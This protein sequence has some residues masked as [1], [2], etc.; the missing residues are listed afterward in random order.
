M[1]KVDLEILIP[2][3]E[4]EKGFCGGEI[5]RGKLNVLSHQGVQC[6]EITLSMG[7]ESFGSGN[8][9]K[10]PR[11]KTQTLYAG[12]LTA[13]EQKTF[14]FEFEAPRYGPFEYEGKHLSIFYF[15]TARANIPM[16]IDPVRKLQIPIHPS[17]E[18]G[19]IYHCANGALHPFDA[20]FDLGNLGPVWGVLLTLLVSGL[21]TIP[22]GF[23]IVTFAPSNLRVPLIFISFLLSMTLIGSTLFRNILAQY[24]VEKPI[25]EIPKNVF[26]PGDVIP[27][28]ISVIAKRAMT[29]NCIKVTFRAAEVTLS[30]SG[31]HQTTYRH[32][33][34]RLEQTFSENLSLQE[35]EEK[36]ILY[37][38]QIPEKTPYYFEFFTHKIF[39]E[40]IVYFDIAGAPDYKITKNI[41]IIPQGYRS[42]ETPVKN[43]Q[44]IFESR[45]KLKEMLAQQKLDAEAD[46]ETN[47]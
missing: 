31:K 21:L 44:E 3:E 4:L 15:L 10:S 46:S 42:A 14:D 1:S 30:G 7:W 19:L 38:I 33:I 11:P 32:E 37:K 17:S 12:P 25:F 24:K 8:L 22:F 2:P 6:K 43:I 16:A 27:F 35:G 34:L 23:I 9:I 26:S 40:L 47:S 18:E 41:F 36:K 45:Y 5:I 39:S 20:H 13:G 28:G 29:L